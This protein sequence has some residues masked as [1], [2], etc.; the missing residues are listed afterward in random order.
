[1]LESHPAFLPVHVVERPVAPENAPP[2]PLG[3]VEIVVDG[4]HTIRVGPGFDADTLRRVLD[5]LGEAES[6]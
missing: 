6:S 1:M 3:P 2:A 5:L 4:R